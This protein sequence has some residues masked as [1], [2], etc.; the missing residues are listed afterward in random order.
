MGKLLGHRL[1]SNDINILSKVIFS[2]SPKM[3]RLIF[4]YFSM[5]I[6]MGIYYCHILSIFQKKKSYINLKFDFTSKLFQNFH[7]VYH[8]NF[9]FFILAF[10][11]SF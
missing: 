8:I 7:I 2:I 10:R 1:L 9:L 11:L 4:T 5:G 6:L 3:S